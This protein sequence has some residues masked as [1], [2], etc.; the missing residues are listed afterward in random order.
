MSDGALPLVVEQQGAGGPL[1][2]LHGMASDRRE[3]NGVAPV[4]AQAHRLIRYDLRGFGQ[5]PHPQKL[6][7]HAE[8]LRLLMDGLGV[9]S[10][11]LLGVSWGGSV[12]LHFTLEHPTRVKRLVLESPSIRGWDWSDNWRARAKEIESIAQSQGVE[13]ARAQWLRQPMFDTLRSHPQEYEAYAT[14]VCQYSGRHWL[15]D[16]PHAPPNQPDVERLQALDTPT[17]LITGG[18]DVA[19]I[20]LIADAIAAIAP[21]VTRIDVPDAGHLVHLERPALFVS[22]VEAFLQQSGRASPSGEFS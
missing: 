9:E 17:L 5:S 15:A 12:A 3:W 20:R 8:D 11:D 14:S 1:I 18:Q 21:K 6:Y 7:S 16:D 22:T 10:C 4:F 13:A 2:L 19:D